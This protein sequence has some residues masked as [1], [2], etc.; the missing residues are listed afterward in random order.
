MPIQALSSYQVGCEDLAH[1][2][3]V[4]SRGPASGS[5]SSNAARRG[6]LSQP[7]PWSWLSDR[8]W[9]SHQALRTCRCCPTTSLARDWGSTRA[10]HRTSRPD[11][12]T[13]PRSSLSRPR[14]ARHTTAMPRSLQRDLETSRCGLR[15]SPT[16]PDRRA[17]KTGTSCWDRPQSRPARRQPQQPPRRG[18]PHQRRCGSVSDVW[19]QASAATVAAARLRTGYGHLTNAATRA[20]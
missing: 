5:G 1:R 8:R 4:S 12:P 13:T 9:R 7:P 2:P 11:G 17:T 6:L 14:P 15:R 10:G 16:S 19:S 20:S 18:R 3:A